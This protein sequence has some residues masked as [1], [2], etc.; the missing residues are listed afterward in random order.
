VAVPGPKGGEASSKKIELSA[1]FTLSDKKS[2]IY[3]WF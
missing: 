1:K 3:S 2:D